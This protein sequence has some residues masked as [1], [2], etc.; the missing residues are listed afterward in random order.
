LIAVTDLSPS[1][2]PEN[3]ERSDV[4]DVM[5]VEGGPWATKQNFEI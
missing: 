3:S 5:A 1:E 4:E 2:K